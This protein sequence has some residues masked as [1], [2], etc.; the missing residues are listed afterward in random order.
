MS[1]MEEEGN[2]KSIAIAVIG[3]DVLVMVDL[4]SVTVAAAN[5]RL[6]LSIEKSTPR[7]L[8]IREDADEV[9]EMAGFKFEMDERDERDGVYEVDVV[10][11]AMGPTAK[12]EKGEKVKKVKKASG[13]ASGSAT[14]DVEGKGEVVE[15]EVHVHG[16]VEG[17]QPNETDTY[18]SETLN[19]IEPIYVYVG[20]I[21]EKSCKCNLNIYSSHRSRKRSSSPSPTKSSV[22]K[23][24][25]ANNHPH[26]PNPTTSSSAALLPIV[27]PDEVN[28]VRRSFY[29]PEACEAD[30][31]C[32]VAGSG[33]EKSVAESVEGDDD[34]GVEE[35]KSIAVVGKGVV[36]VMD[37]KDVTILTPESNGD[38]AGI[39]GEGV[40]DVEV[41]VEDSIVQGNETAAASPTALNSNN[42][43]VETE[44]VD[45]DA[46]PSIS[47]EDFFEY[48]ESGHLAATVVHMALSTVDNVAE[49]GDEDT[50]VCGFYSRWDVET[51]KS[52]KS[53]ETLS[54]ALNTNTDEIETESADHHSFP[55]ISGSDFF[56]HDE[57]G[58]L[59]ATVVQVALS[60]MTYVA[61]SA[62][63]AGSYLP[64]DGDDIFCGF[65]P[66]RDV[67][68][69][70]CLEAVEENEAEATFS[71]AL[72][73]NTDNVDSENVDSDASPE[74]SGAD[75]FEYDEGGCLAETVVQV[76]L[77]TAEYVAGPADADMSVQHLPGDEDE[78]FSGFHPRWQ[79]F[80]NAQ[81]AESSE[82]EAEATFSS[83]P[84]S[85]ID[86]IE[87]ETV[88]VDAS[89]EISGA[90]YFEYDK[91]GCLADT[92]VQVALSTVQNV[93]E[94]ADTDTVIG[95]ISGDED[96]IFMG[97]NT[98]SRDLL[99][100]AGLWEGEEVKADDEP[101]EISQE[102]VQDVTVDKSPST[103]DGDI[104]DFS[105]CTA[106]SESKDFEDAAESFSPL[107]SN[108]DAF[109]TN[110]VDANG[111]LS[112]R[113]S[114]E[115][116]FDFDEGGYAVESAL[117]IAIS[118]L[119]YVAETANVD[120]GTNTTRTHYRFFG[121]G[122]G[123]VGCVRDEGDGFFGYFP[124][125]DA[126][127]A[128]VD[129]FGGDAAESENVSVVNSDDEGNEDTDY[130]DK[131]A[132]GTEGN[133]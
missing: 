63:T 68:Q 8:R 75:F 79:V 53:V 21:H 120:S 66:H 92:V 20:E 72:K 61:E 64:G 74:I 130:D 85:N 104:H 10:D 54:S 27:A 112:A 6:T 23:H 60:T 12:G 129:K 18:T 51:I 16:D 3:K 17:G 97:F 14:S 82:T 62:N 45:S 102:E 30:A 69:N 2:R 5:Q 80:R 58:C 122:A 11:G 86:E 25:I 113:I 67:F 38:E 35:E 98:R 7:T 108:S 56:E 83:A 13:S 55:S 106:D 19:T 87:T 59:A 33:A 84:N 43:E 128:A 26:S 39:V 70:S 132:V 37:L 77:S 49:S 48:D 123:L 46:F 44:T 96:D 71:S 41:D 22:P 95:H 103:S 109:R 100:N 133:K 107:S 121:T 111:T 28:D 115:D 65:H 117:R 9:R 89:P 101:P 119:Q 126:W 4:Q 131:F 99:Q 57:S 114:A 29:L 93:A 42:E 127:K 52:H 88:D 50:I 15:L 81:A 78:I 118:S 124:H 105:S 1:E 94:C 40:C 36:V 125:P 31:A 32:V 24:T 47:G 73:S 110:T 34:D 76:A 91:G 90:D 116:F